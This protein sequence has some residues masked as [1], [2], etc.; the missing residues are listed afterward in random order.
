MR[1]AGVIRSTRLDRLGSVGLRPRPLLH[2]LS[3]RRKGRSGRVAILRRMQVGSRDLREAGRHY[4]GRSAEQD[5][6]Q[7]S[8]LPE[9]RL[10]RSSGG[11]ARRVFQHHQ[12]TYARRSARVPDREQRQCVAQHRSADRVPLRDQ[13]PGGSS[14]G[15]VLVPCASPRI[16][17]CRPRGGGNAVAAAEYDWRRNRQTPVRYPQRAEV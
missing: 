15:S 2:K 1:P 16:A 10:F 12:S 14:G 13:H 7:R 17:A 6:C 5:R 9:R 3:G 4:A 8:Y 11:F